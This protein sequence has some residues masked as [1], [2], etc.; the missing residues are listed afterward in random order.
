[1][2]ESVC[3]LAGI[4]SPMP[5][6]VRRFA[7]PSIVGLLASL[8]IFGVCFYQMP[9]YA[10][11]IVHNSRGSVG[12][13]GLNQI[14]NGRFGLMFRNLAWAK[15]GFVEANAML[16]LWV[17]FLVGVLGALPIGV[18][19]EIELTR[20]SSVELREQRPFIS[21]SRHPSRAA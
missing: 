11:I 5:L 14:R 16:C 13:L 9:Y 3:L 21:V 1:V 2:A 7:I 19:V 17:L 18:L 6:R 12:A 8:E 15:P 10:G 20:P 4:T